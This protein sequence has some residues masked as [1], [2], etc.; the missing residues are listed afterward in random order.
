MNCVSC[1]L[2]KKKITDVGR[3]IGRTENTTVFSHDVTVGMKL[4]FIP[5]ILV[6][7]STVIAI[8]SWLLDVPNERLLLHSV[9]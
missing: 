4:C 5:T 1:G 3:S 8:E 2:V 6:V 9:P 7:V